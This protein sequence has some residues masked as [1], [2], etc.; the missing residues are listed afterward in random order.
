MPVPF[1]HEDG[2]EGDVEVKVISAHLA[3]SVRG[4]KMGEPEDIRCTSHLRRGCS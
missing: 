2:C 3:T 4:H 1:V